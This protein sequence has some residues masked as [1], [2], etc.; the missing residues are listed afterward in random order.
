MNTVALHPNQG[1]LIAGDEDG[2]LRVWD[3]AANTCS[4]ELVP[5]G[6]TAIRSICVASDASIVLAATNR[7]AVF[8][9]RLGRGN[10]EALH[11]IDAH[12]TYC[13]TA[14]LSPDVKYLATTSADKTV[15]IWNA[16]NGFKLDKTLQGHAAWVYDASF[17][18]DSA[19]LVTASSDRTA[20]VERNIR[21]TRIADSKREQ[22]CVRARAAEA[23]LVCYFRVFASVRIAAVGS[24]CRQCDSR[25]QGP[26]QSHHRGGTQRLQLN[27]SAVASRA[28]LRSIVSLSNALHFDLRAHR[29][30]W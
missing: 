11:K 7:G 12:S 21:N 29:R 8:C 22:Y 5:D 25:L 6:K 20:K 19:Y 9:W 26:Q 3:L 13:L 10:F 1:E 27:S 2:N 23:H 24:E 14:L 18:A 16:E 15:K 17:S 30:V 4:Y 28:F